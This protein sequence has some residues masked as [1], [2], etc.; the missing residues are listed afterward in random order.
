MYLTVD[1]EAYEI[2]TT[3]AKHF[4]RY[5]WEDCLSVFKGSTLVL[6]ISDNE[7][8]LSRYDLK[9][10]KAITGTKISFLL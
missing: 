5:N 2:E 4:Y 7:E 6:Y 8:V 1:T 9:P 10:N 3:D